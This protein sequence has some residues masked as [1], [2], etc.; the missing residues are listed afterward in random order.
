MGVF[1]ALL[2]FPAEWDSWETTKHVKLSIITSKRLN[3]TAARIA[4][5]WSLMSKVW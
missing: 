1:I 3:K 5:G 2:Y 4:S